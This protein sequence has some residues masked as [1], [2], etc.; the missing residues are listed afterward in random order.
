MHPDKIFRCLSFLPNFVL[1]TISAWP[2]YSGFLIKLLDLGTNIVCETL[3]FMLLW[4]HN[5]KTFNKECC[6]GE[7]VVNVFLIF[8]SFAVQCNQT[9]ELFFSWLLWVKKPSLGIDAMPH[10]WKSLNWFWGLIPDGSDMHVYPIG[11]Q[12]FRESEYCNVPCICISSFSTWW[13]EY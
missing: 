7:R 5:V 10:C 11:D 12:I 9:S 2:A 3:K 8:S 4:H 13:G 6:L 1:G